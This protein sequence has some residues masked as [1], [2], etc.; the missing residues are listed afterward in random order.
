MTTIEEQLSLMDWLRANGGIG[1]GCGH[2]EDLFSPDAIQ[3]EAT[4]CWSH[5]L[6]EYCREERE[7]YV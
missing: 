5:H 7:E 3:T 1:S 2:E 4:G 6:P